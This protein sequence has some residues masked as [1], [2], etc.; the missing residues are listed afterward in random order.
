MS[1][2][3]R[4]TDHF[5]NHFKKLDRYTQKILSSWIKKNLVGCENPRLKGKP[6]IG[7]KKSLWRYRIGDY[8]IF[9]EI[10]DGE[11]VI[12]AMEVGHRRDIYK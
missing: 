9:C 7:N 6:L 5:D 1:Y 11:L 4:T 2:E 12:F 8:R 3:V 10:D